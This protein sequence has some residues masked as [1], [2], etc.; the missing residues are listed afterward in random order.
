MIKK[1]LIWSIVLL[2]LF[3]SF[4]S[5]GEKYFNEGRCG[6]GELIYENDIPVLHL[7]GNPEERGR[8]YGTLLKPQINKML[9]V[10]LPLAWGMAVKNESS[11]EIMS[12]IRSME[13]KIPDD[14][15][16]EMKSAA[17]AADVP[18][19]KLLIGNTLSDAKKILECSTVCVYDDATSGGQIFFVRHLDFPSLGL[20][21]KLGLVVVYHV[22][23]GYDFAS[24]SF[25]GFMGV[26]TGMNEKGLSIGVMETYGYDFHPGRKPYCMQ[27]REILQS[28]AYGNEAKSFLE[29]AVFATSNN[30]MICDASGAPFVAEITPDKTYFRYPE[31]DSVFSTNHFESKEIYQGGGCPRYAFLRKFTEENHGNITLDQVK[32]SLRKTA[33]PLLNIQAMIFEPD[34]LHLH[35]SMGNIPAAKGTYSVLNAADFR[36]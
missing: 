21:N 3:G 2:L 32:L 1:N 4:A 25:P 5:A 16:T 6:K 27:F 26:L 14:V 11:E 10:T 31:K 24:V 13:E 34:D 9:N 30:L 15:M 19:K 18:Y 12:R 20:L 22:E 23:N 29:K 33:I 8:Q 35:L 28:C 36:F 17:E 7:Y